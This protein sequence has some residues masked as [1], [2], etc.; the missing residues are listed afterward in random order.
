MGA[1]IDS[2]AWSG[3]G[4]FTRRLLDELAAMDDVVEVRVEDSPASRSDTGFAFL[5]NEIFVLAATRAVQ[6]R[7]PWLRVLS[8]ER[9]A[10]EP[11]LSLGALAERL[12]AVAN[13]GEPDYQD[14]GM[15]QYL[16]TERVV[17]PWQTKG[18]KVVEMVRV[19][20]AGTAPRR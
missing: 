6:R 10:Q 7:E 5:S 19:Y 3:D 4:D 17:A 20:A 11:V 15:L 18:I 1:R 9:E 13:L 2:Q 12:A 14:E 16:R 8:R